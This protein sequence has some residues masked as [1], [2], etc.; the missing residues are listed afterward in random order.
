MNDSHSEF[1]KT[2]TTNRSMDV[3]FTY[4]DVCFVDDMA[5]KDDMTLAVHISQIVSPT[6]TLLRI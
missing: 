4:F 1:N 5:F 3:C 2:K 6:T